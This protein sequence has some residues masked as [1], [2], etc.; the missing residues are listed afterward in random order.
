MTANDRQELQNR[1]GSVQARRNDA[2]TGELLLNAQVAD[3][4]FDSQTAYMHEAGLEPGP[5][6]FRT[7]TRTPRLALSDPSVCRLA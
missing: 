3:S 1:P 4:S 2:V 7:F 6:G 5:Q